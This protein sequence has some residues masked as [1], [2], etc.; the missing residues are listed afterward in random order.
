MKGVYIPNAIDDQ[1]EAEK[2]ITIKFESVIII[3][4]KLWDEIFVLGDCNEVVFFK[5]I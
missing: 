1:K 2:S 3:V 4:S 5:E